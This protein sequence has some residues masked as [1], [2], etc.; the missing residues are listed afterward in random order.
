MPVE[1]IQKL[2][3]E[4]YYWDMRI[5]RLECNYFADDIELVYDDSEGFY[6]IYR[7]NGCYRSN[8]DHVKNYDKFCPVREMSIAQLSY[9]LQDVKIGEIEENGVHFYTCKINMFP[10]YLEIWCKDIQIVRQKDE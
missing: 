7:F 6:V 1:E 10:L 8:F 9:F 3:D 5:V 2:I 4:Y